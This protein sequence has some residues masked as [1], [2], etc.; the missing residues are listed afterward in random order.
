[1]KNKKEFLLGLLVLVT[2]VMLSFAQDSW[3]GRLELMWDTANIAEMKN[4]SLFLHSPVQQEI[5]ITHDQPWEGNV[6]CYHTVF[7]D[8]DQYRMYYRGAN[9]D[10]KRTHPEFTCYAE[11]KDGVKWHKPELGLIEFNGSKANNIIWQG[12]G[13]HNFAP[14]RDT[15]PAC[16]PEQKYKAIGNTDPAE[17][18][19]MA[20]VSAD[21][22]NWQP[23]RDDPILTRQQGRFDTHNTVFWDSTKGKY[24]IYLRDLQNRVRAVKVSYSDD[25]RQWSEPEWLTYECA[26]KQEA[27]YTNAIQPYPYAPDVYI[28]FPMRFVERRVAYWCNEPGADVG[29]LSDGLFMSSRNGQHFKLWYNAFLRPGLRPERWI[30]RN[31]MI[32]WGVVE[33]ECD[34]SEHIREVSLYS[35]ENYY[36]HTPT[37]LRRMS[38]RKDGFVSLRALDKI[39]SIIMQP[40]VFVCQNKDASLLVNVSTSASGS[41]RCE[42]RDKHNKP[43]PGFSFDECIPLYG[44]GIALPLQWKNNN[45]VSTLSGKVISICFEIQDAD[46]FSFSM[47]TTPVY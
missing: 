39:G 30:N 46:L 25:F 36:S 37:R 26:D 44:D 19:L 9:W 31:N 1:M 5:A 11:S 3:D 32:A 33:T 45:K 14:F 21:G 16:P 28:G 22:I 29:G 17:L 24:A 13:A 12:C 7:Q 8:D 27:L 47:G 18:G 40:V 4:T 20:F 41:L 43:L 35:T 23:L 15:N 34:V 10:K 42:I 38:V 2:S 6:C